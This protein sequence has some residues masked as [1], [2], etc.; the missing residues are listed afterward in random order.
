MWHTHVCNYSFQGRCSGLNSTKYRF[1]VHV[2]DWG[3]DHS[4]QLYMVCL[5]EAA[6][7]EAAA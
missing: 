3:D 1:V 4:L 5:C 2:A 7:T 6:G